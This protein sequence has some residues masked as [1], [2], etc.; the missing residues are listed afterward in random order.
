MKRLVAEEYELIG[1]NS[2]RGIFEPMCYSGC[3]L[4]NRYDRYWNSYYRNYVHRCD[5]ADFSY[6]ATI[7]EEFSW[8]VRSVY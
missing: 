5:G 8:A 7:V 4:E 2:P 6:A 1:P 3:T